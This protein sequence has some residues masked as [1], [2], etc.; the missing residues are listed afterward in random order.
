MGVNSWFD[1][2]NGA[3]RD[4]SLDDDVHHRGTQAIGALQ[5]RSFGRSQVVLHL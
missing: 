3:T 5:I 1:G 2:P 4:E